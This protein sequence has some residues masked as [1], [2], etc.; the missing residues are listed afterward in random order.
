MSKWP[1]SKKGKIILSEWDTK[2]TKIQR[3]L[4]L[5]DSSSER[6]FNSEDAEA[7]LAEVEDEQSDRKSQVSYECLE[8][9]IAYADE[10]LADEE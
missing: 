9:D 5:S 4:S 1:R 7:N 10:P 3:N 2:T 8:N 6:S